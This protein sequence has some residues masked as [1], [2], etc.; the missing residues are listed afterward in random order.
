MFASALG[1]VDSSTD[2]TSDS[3][4]CRSNVMLQLM[5]ADVI[6]VSVSVTI[7]TVAS[8]DTLK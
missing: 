4:I 1:L 6:K 8:A 2:T 7:S 3:C 5:I